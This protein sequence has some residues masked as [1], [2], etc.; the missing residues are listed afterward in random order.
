MAELTFPVYSADALVNFFRAEV[1]TGQEAKQFGKSDLI[2]VPKPESIQALY[3]RVL[4]LL[5]RFRPELHSMVPLLVNIANPQYHE[6]T[7]A[8]TSVFM[9]ITIPP[10][11]QVEADELAA[12]LSEL[13][14]TATHKFQESNVTNEVIAE[15]KTK[16]AEKTQKLTQVKVDVSNLKED[17]SKLRSQIVQSPEELKSQ[18][19]RMRENVKTI[20]C[21]IEDTDGR[22]VELQS[23][24][25][26]VTHTEAK[27]QQMFN[28]LQDLESSMTNSKQREQEHQEL[29]AQYEKKLKEL[30]NLCS[31]EGQL[32]RTL[33]MKLDK[34]SKLNI[35]RQKKKEM[36]EQHAQ[37]VLGEYNQIH[38][39]REE[40]A[41][42][43]QEISSETQQ[44]KA[45]I[46]SL[47][48]VCSKETKKAQALYDKLSTSM[49]A[50][51][52]RI[53]VQTANVKQGL[54][55]K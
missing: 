34:E 8:I 1:L 55:K 15:L 5:Y 35:R 33:G 11:Q 12:S 48:D 38:Q 18:M 27:L 37:E 36:K 16:I 32:K 46:R 49:D 6:A 21:T 30:K 41:D 39:K 9:L 42:K 53:D 14:T 10:E 26:S 3:M 24:M 23:M 28:L 17:V 22:V 4:H 50:M 25:Q 52:R 47:R 31:E 29:T 51:H 20:K 2:P 45:K 7:L 44:L 19:E 43:I 40:M 54:G 13:Q